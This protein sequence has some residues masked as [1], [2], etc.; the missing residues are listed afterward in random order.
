M[1]PA[2]ARPPETRAAVLVWDLPVRVVHGLMALSFV[3]AWLTA[4][5]EDWL[6]LHVTLGFTMGGLIAFRLLWGVVGTR[7]AR[8]TQFLRGP[9]GVQ[10][11]ARAVLDDRPRHHVGHNPLGGLAIVAMLGLGAAAVASGWAADQGLAGDGIADL[12]EAVVSA[13]LFAIGVH[14]AGALVSSALQHENLP[15]AMVTGRKRGRPADAIT[16]ARG[17]VAA[18]VLVAVLG[19]WLLRW[20]EPPAPAALQVRRVDDGHQHPRHHPPPPRGAR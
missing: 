6:D 13:L 17:P 9:A 11:Y 4:E 14:I 15:W 12:H 3:G 2:A 8:F 5:R 1:P 20:R 16:S 19:F 18:V 10:A 7:H